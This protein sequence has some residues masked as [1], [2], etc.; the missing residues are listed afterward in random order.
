MDTEIE[1][2]KWCDRCK[3][4]FPIVPSDKAELE[5]ELKSRL[6]FGYIRMGLLYPKSVISKTLKY[7]FN[8]NTSNYA[9]GNCILDLE[10]SDVG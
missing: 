3:E 7:A 1:D 6:G 5:K 4:E 10:D 2:N 8:Q 9:C